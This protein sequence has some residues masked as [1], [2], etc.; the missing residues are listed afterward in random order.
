MKTNTYEI[1]NMIVHP[2]TKEIVTEDMFISYQD[3]KTTEFIQAINC[4]ETKTDNGF[5]LT[6]EIDGVEFTASLTDEEYFDGKNY[7][8][9]EKK[10]TKVN[11]WVWTAKTES[12]KP[13]RKAGEPRKCTAVRKYN[14]ECGCKQ[15]VGKG[16]EYYQVGP[17]GTDYKLVHHKC[18]KKVKVIS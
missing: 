15:E 13:D 11:E 6:G 1:G 3:W 5:V 16:T 18:I 2:V 10:S 14:C 17:K 7:M 9:N 4:K 8:L 12:L